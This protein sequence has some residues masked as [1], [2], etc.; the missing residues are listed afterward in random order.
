MSSVPDS[1]WVRSYV[2]N[3][4]EAG[5]VRVAD[6]VR[7][8]EAELGF[9]RGEIQAAGEHF[10]VISQDRHGELYWMRPANLSAI[11]WGVSPYAAD[12]SSGMGRLAKS[13]GP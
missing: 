2:L 12:V 5:P 4:L 13:Q 1:A 3:S 6:L 8:G 7:I 9:S 11:W 10:A